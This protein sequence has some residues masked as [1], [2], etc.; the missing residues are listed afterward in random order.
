MLYGHLL[1]ATY[2]LLV[3]IVAI[4]LTGSIRFQEIPSQELLI[5]LGEN[6]GHCIV[7]PENSFAIAGDLIL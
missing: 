2:Y 4:A 6:Q 5:L 1:L 3:S 7:L